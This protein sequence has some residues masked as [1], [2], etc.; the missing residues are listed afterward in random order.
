MSMRISKIS[1]ALSLLVSIWPAALLADPPSHAP[2]HGWRMKNDPH[3]RGYS[4]KQWPTDYGIL[5]G[6]CNREAVATVLGGMAGAAIGSSV[7]DDDD[8]A[9]AVIIGAAAGA[10]IGN[11]IGRELDEADRAC[12]G[13]AL[14]I[15]KTGQILAWVNKSTGVSYEMTVLT[16]ASGQDNACRQFALSADLGK[17]KSSKQGRACHSGQGVWEI[18]GQNISTLVTEKRH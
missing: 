18:D 4:G 3:Y 1:L 6:R 9:V 7:G 12:V 2:A 11:R 5:S 17:T 13:H 8:R 14:E 16:D 10:L 15:G